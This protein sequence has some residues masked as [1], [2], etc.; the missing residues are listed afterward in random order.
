MKTKI[1]DYVS[2]LIY[3]NQ[4]AYQIPEKH[5]KIEKTRQNTVVFLKALHFFNSSHIN[6][7][8]SVMITARLIEENGKLLHFSRFQ[9]LRKCQV[10]RLSQLSGYRQLRYGQRTLRGAPLRM[11]VISTGDF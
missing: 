3:L 8:F 6:T 5:S 10:S 11:C 9:V 1:K 4:N 7:R 2:K